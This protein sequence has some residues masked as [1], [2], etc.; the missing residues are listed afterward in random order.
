M[1]HGGLFKTPGVGQRYLAA[2]TQTPVWVME[3]AGE[4]GPYGMALLAL[5]Q[6][7]GQGR[8]LSRFLEE[9]IFAGASGSV[10]QPD[11]ADAAGFGAYLDR[12]L[13]A[14]NVERAAIDH[15]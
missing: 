8:T 11:A 2:A 12:F 4:G 7:K 6:R 5:Y 15:L 14:L 10:M 1:G 13:R 3:T 9:D